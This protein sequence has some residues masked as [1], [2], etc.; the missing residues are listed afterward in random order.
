M[1]YMLICVVG[2]LLVCGYAGFKKGIISIAL[3]IVA[4]VVTILAT[5][6]IAPVCA[7]IVKEHTPIYDQIYH[8]VEQTIRKSNDFEQAVSDTVGN[9]SEQEQQVEGN[10]DYAEIQI[11]VTQI[12]DMLKLPDSISNTL[13]GTTANDYVK[14]LQQTGAT[15]VRNMIVAV[16]AQRMTYIIFHTAIHIIV[17]LVIYLVLR[18]VFYVTNLIGKLPVIQQANHLLGLAAGLV[19]GIFFI[20]IAFALLTACSGMEWAAAALADIHGH[21]LLSWLYDNNIIMHS[22]LK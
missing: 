10:N 17:F 20:W 15:T 5:L 4:M 12:C 22:I 18:I 21:T 8:A 11:Y 1:N 7:T 3:S 2:L 9:E 19:E 6:V 14:D 13:A 16:I